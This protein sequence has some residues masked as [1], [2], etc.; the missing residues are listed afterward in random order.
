MS[1]WYSAPRDA[2]IHLVE[3]WLAVF[4]T[5]A[6]AWNIPPANVTD[7]TTALAAAREI[8]A[9]V[10]SGERTAAGV[11]RCNEAFREM[12]TE[13]RFIKRHYLL[14]PPLTPPDLA[15]LLLPQPDGTYTPVP[16]PAGQPVLSVT[17]PGGP[18]LLKVHLA[19]LAGT[20]PPDARSD[21]G[22]ALYRGVMPQGGASL[23]QAASV[24]HYLM[25]PPLSGEELLHYRFTR[26]RTELVGFAAEESGMTAYFC[27]RYENDKG[28][29]GVWGPVVSAV[30]P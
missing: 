2:Q 21:Y 13:A 22:Y 23:E 1:D 30:I 17:Y 24:K 28:E 29:A 12:E 19:P 25:R 16:P 14:L 7:L 26:R 15:D 5:K 27:S 4:Q 20:E 11:V 18:H 6:P 8:L 10:K 3:T 9:V